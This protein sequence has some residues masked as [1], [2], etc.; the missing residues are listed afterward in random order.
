MMTLAP[1]SKRKALLV[2]S[3]ATSEHGG[4]RERQPADFAVP[5]DI[6]PVGAGSLNARMNANDKL[7]DACRE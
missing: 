1:R 6:D 5:V 3:L 4:L 2:R 7:A